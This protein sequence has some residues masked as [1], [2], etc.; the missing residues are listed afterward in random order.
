MTR[1]RVRNNRLALELEGEA[2]NSYRSRRS[3]V[4]SLATPCDGAEATCR[5]MIVKSALAR[6]A[7]SYGVC[8]RSRIHTA[9]RRSTRSTK[10]LRWTR[11]RAS[12]LLARPVGSPSHYSSP[13]LTPTFARP[14]V[15]LPRTFDALGRE[16]ECGSTK[17]RPLARPMRPDGCPLWSRADS[18]VLRLERCRSR[19]G[20]RSR[21]RTR[22]G[23]R[24]TCGALSRQFRSVAQQDSAALPPV[25][26][27]LGT[28]VPGLRARDWQRSHAIAVASSQPTKR[29]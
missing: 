15:V 9:R 17:L 7:K 16:S 3:V 27:A 22:R 13:Q 4:A 8:W 29:R 26:R 10:P 2:Q 19:S 5:V 20:S 28:C 11:R 14:V 18:N 23:S 12:E 25:P 24:R 21:S 6:R 1:S